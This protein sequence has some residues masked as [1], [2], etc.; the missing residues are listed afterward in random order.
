MTAL[1]LVTRSPRETQA[2]GALLGR[3]AQPGDVILLVGPLGAGKT[4][5]VQGLAR[6]LG[7]QDYVTSPSFTIMGEYHGRMPLYH[8]DCFRIESPE[9]AQELGLE[10]YFGGGGLSVVEWADKVLEALPPQHLLVTLEYLGDRERALRL[11][12]RGPR[13][14]DL[15]EALRRK[16]QP[17]KSNH[18]VHPTPGH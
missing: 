13:Y 4:C 17:G 9:E 18:E 8:I 5:L 14:A 2:L 1:E 10:D 11:E 16:H 3:L 6:G 7:V 12:A 15:L